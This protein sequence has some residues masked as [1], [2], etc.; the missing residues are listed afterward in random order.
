MRTKKVGEAS[1]KFERKEIQ[2]KRKEE[3]E[4]GSLRHLGIS[5]PDLLAE[6]ALGIKEDGWTPTQD[7]AGQTH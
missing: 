3:T 6:G 1:L 4:L 2:S 7:K 5:F